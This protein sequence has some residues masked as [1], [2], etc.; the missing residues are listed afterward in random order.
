MFETKGLQELKADCFLCYFFNF[1]R[2][3]RHSDASLSKATVQ[4]EINLTYEVA[5]QRFARGLELAC[6][7][8]AEDE[9][10]EAA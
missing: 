1:R 6:L 10:S 5:W 3:I 2:P 8:L 7:R 9:A 4:T